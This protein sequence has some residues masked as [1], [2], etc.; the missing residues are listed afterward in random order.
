MPAFTSTKTTA[1]SI[2]FTTARRQEAK[3]SFCNLGGQKKAGPLL[4][5][6]DHRGTADGR[7]IRV[8]FS[9]VSV[10]VTSSDQWINAE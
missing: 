1:S 5:S 10:K 3:P 4:I 8:F 9:D 6:T 2:L 7:P